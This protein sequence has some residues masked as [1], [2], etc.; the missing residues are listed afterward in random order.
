MSR[1]NVLVGCERSGVVRDEFLRLGHF[2]V[3]CDLEPDLSGDAYTAREQHYQGD[4]FELLR[5][6]WLTLPGGERYCGGWDLLIAHPPCTYLSCSAEWA[7]KDGP[8]HMK[9]KPG[10]LLGA[11]RRVA[12]AA[13]INF[14][15]NLSNAPGLPLRVCIENPI[16]VM[17]RHYLPPSQKIQPYQFGDDASKATC[18]WL[19]ELS[20]LVIDPAKR[21]PGRIV[22]TDKRG[23][24]IERWANQTDSGQNRLT[25]SAE[26]A[27]LRAVTYKGIAEAMAQ[28]WGG[29]AYG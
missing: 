13:A 27:H 12:R 18:L 25:P 14:F 5:K 4:V 21:I 26:R 8:Y 20:P 10:T 3:S 24:P 1:L 23:K 16:G 22:G 28:Q 15:I 2:A 7:Y 6:P 11:E 17:R 29:D 19:Q 9:C